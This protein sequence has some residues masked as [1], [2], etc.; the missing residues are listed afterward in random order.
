MNLFLKIPYV[1]MCRYISSTSAFIKNSFIYFKG[2]VQAKIPPPFSSSF[3][4]F[5]HIHNIKVRFIYDEALISTDS[6][7]IF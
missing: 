4:H 1:S 6:I 5:I 7:F 2:K 3:S